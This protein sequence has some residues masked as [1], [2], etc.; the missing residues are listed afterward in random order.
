MVSIELQDTKPLTFDI[1]TLSHYFL[2]E[3][4][5]A[6]GFLSDTLVYQ[7]SRSGLRAYSINKF[8]K[9]NYKGSRNASLASAEIFSVDLNLDLY[10]ESS[11]LTSDLLNNPQPPLAELRRFHNGVSTTLRNKCSAIPLPTHNSL[12]YIYNSQ[13]ESLQFIPYSEYLS[14]IDS[15][16]HWKLCLGVLKGLYEGTIC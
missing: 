5:I 12:I 6:V 11:K 13:I 3:N 1:R 16:G 9:G 15:E 8:P 14:R 2:A 10:P 4:S 7:F